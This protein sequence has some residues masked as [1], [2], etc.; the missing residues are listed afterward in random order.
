[1]DSISKKPLM[2]AVFNLYDLK[3]NLLGEYTTDNNGIIEFPR[4]I[5]SGK[6]KIKE[7]R[8]PENYVL[9]DTVKTIE[10][11]QGETTEILVENQPVMGQIQIVKKAADDNPINRKKAG[12]A[13]E[14]AKFEIY[15]DRLEVVDTITT[16]SR[17]I[18]TSKELP[19]GTYGIKEVEPPEFYS[20]DGKVFYAQIRAAKDLIRFEVLNQSEDIQVSVEKRGNVEVVAGDQMRYDFSNIENKSNI[21]LDDFYWHDLLPPEVRLERVYTGT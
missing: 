8:A 3:N 1:M 12:A 7:T 5:A 16:D 14:G 9:D 11:K 13:L 17:G 19:V 15:N 6:Y 4:S 20:T 10:V 18:A 21:D 2:G